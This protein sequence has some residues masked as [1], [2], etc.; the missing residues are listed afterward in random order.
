DSLQYFLSDDG[1]EIPKRFKYVNLNYLHGYLN[2]N[3]A[4]GPGFKMSSLALSFLFNNISLPTSIS[5]ATITQ[6]WATFPSEL[7]LLVFSSHP[8]LLDVPFDDM[9]I[10]LEFSI[11]PDL[12]QLPPF[13]LGEPSCLSTKW[14]HK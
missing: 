6:M 9:T 4:E 13:L 10:P 14:S 3:P 12:P 5:D 1:Y 7:L 11:V 8:E 2:G